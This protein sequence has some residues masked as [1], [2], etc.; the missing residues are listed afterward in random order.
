MKSNRQIKSGGA[1]PRRWDWVRQAGLSRL[2][3]VSTLKIVYYTI[4]P[5]SSEKSDPP[6]VAT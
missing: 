4:S 1:N 2:Q 5:K 6:R 3:F